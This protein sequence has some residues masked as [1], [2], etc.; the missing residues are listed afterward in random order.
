[1]RHRAFTL[2]E[3]LVALVI[4]AA[5]AGAVYRFMAG[6]SE[7]RARIEVVVTR[8]IGVTRLFSMIETDLL[9]CVAVADDGGAGVKGDASNL[10]IKRRAVRLS[11]ENAADFADATETE[12]RFDRSASALSAER[13]GR[14]AEPLLDDI[15]LVK[16]RYFHNGEWKENFD[17]MNIGTVPA[18]VEVAVWFRMNASAEAVEGALKTGALKDDVKLPPPDRI[19]VVGVH[20][21]VILE[22][23]EP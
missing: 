6:I 2:T 7:D 19:L 5:L 22:G 9:T 4:I 18:A 16:F 12:Y 8:N 13:D 20:D 15:A 23:D 21:A 3:V 14:G 1:M 10:R 11:A 17:S